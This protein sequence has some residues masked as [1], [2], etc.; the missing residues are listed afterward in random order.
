MLPIVEAIEDPLY[1]RVV[2]I[3]AAQ[4]SKTDTI[5]NVLGHRAQDDPTPALYV[6]PSKNFVETQFEPRLMAMIRSVPEL[7][8]RLE[9]GKRNRKTHK[10]ISGIDLR[11]AWAGS[12]TELSSASIGLGI[13]DERDRMR[14]DVGGQGD[15]VEMVESRGATYPGFT[16][17]IFTTPTNG[18]VEVELDEASGILRWK[19]ALPESIQSPGWKLWQEGTR[20][21]WAWPCPR[22]ERYFVP[23]FRHLVWPKDASPHAA[24]SL[25]RVKCPQ[26]GGEIDS[27][28]KLAMNEHGVYLAPG[29]RAVALGV[30]EG[31]PPANETASF[32]VSGLCSPWRTFGRSAS[33]WLQAVRSGDPERVKA[34]RN[35]EF[36]ELYAVAGEAPKIDVVAELRLPYRFEEVPDEVRMITCGV[37]VQKL[38]LFYVVRGWGYRMESWLLKHGFIAGETELDPV[39]HDLELVVE[40]TW[41][42]R[43][44]PIRQTFV[45]SGYK[46]GDVWRRPEHR[47]YR[48]CRKFPGYARPSKGHDEL[49][50]T[51]KLNRIDVTIGNRKIKRAV[52]LAHVNT[53]WAKSWIHG[54]IA[55]PKDQP[56][57]WHLAADTEDA[58]CAQIIAE[59]RIT[60]ASGRSR[61]I[62]K[63]ANHY[64]DCEVLA[65]AAAHLL[66]V[67]L[68]KDTGP[69]T[70]PKAPAPRGPDEPAVVPRGSWISTRPDFL[71]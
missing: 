70:T 44:L 33:R 30:V 11:L 7:W 53:D 13:I 69:Q 54:R 71:G 31:E 18:L 64:L 22:C 43:A 68:L 32:W 57:G 25:A 4:L 10:R 40:S 36:G 51:V 23:R 66:G 63:G 52:E 61:W 45:D 47:V 17:A 8:E 20:H 1:K 19:V 56:G 37:D 14:G 39:W 49:D 42:E 24:L 60:L 62:E 38:G 5:L 9:K 29:Q 67:H 26:C 27:T 55:W 28:E 50:T 41:G 58:Y 16:L 46:P 65:L 48:F 12:A 3:T 2:A 6:G 15:P 21:E 35:L 59:S 34:A